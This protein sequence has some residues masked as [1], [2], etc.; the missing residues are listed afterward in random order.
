MI[1]RYIYKIFSSACTIL[2]PTFCFSC[3]H[4]LYEQREELNIRFSASGPNACLVTY[5]VLIKSATEVK[6]VSLYIC[7]IVHLQYNVHATL[8]LW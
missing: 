6:R 2:P 4:T 5:N 3:Y 8:F 1:D 7:R